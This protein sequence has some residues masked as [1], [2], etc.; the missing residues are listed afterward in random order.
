MPP[1]NRFRNTQQNKSKPKEKEILTDKG[2]GK[3][4]AQEILADSTQPSL[5]KR[6]ASSHDLRAA[7]Q[8]TE[9]PSGAPKRFKVQIPYTQQQDFQAKVRFSLVGL[10]MN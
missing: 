4:V 5:R 9:R 3:G 2:K 6:S 10:M 7:A 1:R 8:S